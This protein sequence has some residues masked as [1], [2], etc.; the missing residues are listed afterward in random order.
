MHIDSA[1]FQLDSFSRIWLWAVRRGRIPAYLQRPPGIS[2]GGEKLML[3]VNSSPAEHFVLQ[4]R[5][6]QGYRASKIL[7][8]QNQQSN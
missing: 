6:A 8:L 5:W 4:T 7:R 1:Q 3:C 2:T